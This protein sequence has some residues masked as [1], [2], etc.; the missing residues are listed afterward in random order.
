MQTNDSKKRITYF[1]SLN[2]IWYPFP[3]WE[4]PFCQKRSKSV[5]P[6]TQY[7]YCVHFV[8]V[9]QNVFAALMLK[10]SVKKFFRTFY[11]ISCTFLSK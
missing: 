5:Y 10:I 1:V 3:V 4:A 9:L 2:S 8:C 6:T 11:D 7:T